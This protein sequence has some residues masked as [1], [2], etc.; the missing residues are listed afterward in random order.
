MFICRIGK[1]IQYLIRFHE[2]VRHC[3]IHLVLM[4][5]SNEMFETDSLFHFIYHLEMKNVFKPM[6]RLFVLTAFEL[7]SP[8][9][10]CQKL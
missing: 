6:F 10:M 5:I 3:S 2:Y 4:S 8:N 7:L 9:A 1:N